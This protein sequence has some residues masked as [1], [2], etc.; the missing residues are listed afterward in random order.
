MRTRERPLC[1]A[2][3]PDTYEGLCAL[4]MPRTIHDDVGRDNVVEIT[5]AMAGHD[6]NGDQED[7]FVLLCELVASYEAVDPPEIGTAEALGMLLEEHGMSGAD[8]A[9]VL[10]LHRT[11][12]PKILS[13]DRSLTAEHIRS[14]CDR[15]GVGSGYFL[16]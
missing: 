8:L 2:D 7:Y 5:D 14:L 9:R 6:L 16:A 1:F 15:F 13:G 10:G 3:L 12:G 11:M 4:L